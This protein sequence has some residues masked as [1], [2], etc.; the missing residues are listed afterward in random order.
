[1]APRASEAS[2][3]RGAIRQTAQ[4]LVDHSAPDF[5]A[6]VAT[7][8]LDLGRVF[9]HVAAASTAARSPHAGMTS[10]NALRAFNA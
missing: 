5:F 7:T 3:G 1:M 9:H 2:C 10:F 8:P 6:L 4:Q